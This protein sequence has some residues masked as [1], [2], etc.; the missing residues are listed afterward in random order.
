MF[1]AGSAINSIK[2][3]KGEYDPVLGAR[4]MTEA[5]AVH[6]SGALRD[7]S[8]EEHLDALAAH[9]RKEGLEALLESLRQRYPGRVE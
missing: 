6:Q 3:A 8:L 1:L 4:A 2:N 5:L 7:V 9:A